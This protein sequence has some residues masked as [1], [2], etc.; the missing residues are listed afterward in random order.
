M[1]R[2]AGA[3]RSDTNANAD[4]NANADTH[5]NADTSGNAGAVTDTGAA[6]G[7][8]SVGAGVAEAFVPLVVTDREAARF[9]GRADSRTLGFLHVSTVRGPARTTLALDAST[10]PGGHLLLGVLS[11][12]RARLVPGGPDAHPAGQGEPEA[13]LC[14]S[15]LFVLDGS[16]PFAL[17]AYEGFRLHLLR[18]PC[19]SLAVTGERIRDLVR[20]DLPLRGPVASLLA[21][22]LRTLAEEAPGYSA[23]TAL[24]LAGNVAELVAALAVEAGDNGA[25]PAR[26]HEREELTRRLRAHIDES[27][28]DRGLSPVTVAAAHHVSIRHLHNL[29][30]EH[31]STVGRWIQHRR[32]E[33]ARRELARPGR[34][35]TGVAVVAGRW[36]FASAAHFSRSF[37]T[38]Y[39]MSPSDWR[40]SRVRPPGNPAG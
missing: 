35:D 2:T 22:L 11:D 8:A 33:E 5:M 18:I 21:P 34:T 16:T 38:A 32:L 15:D 30:S 20:R 19:A 23:R 31:D 24:H 14:P 40:D 25:R 4:I 6:P 26:R 7:P 3:D 28:W 27:L 17:H 9:T 39:G 37:R 12:G 10:T 29:F 36:G 1:S 13:A